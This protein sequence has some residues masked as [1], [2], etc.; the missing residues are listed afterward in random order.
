ML[1]MGNNIATKGVKSLYGSLMDSLQMEK[2]NE[3][4]IKLSGID[5]VLI[6][7]IV[8]LVIHVFSSKMWFDN[9]GKY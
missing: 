1:R 4:V 5:T 2:L 7:I 8:S 3:G 6:I 9:C